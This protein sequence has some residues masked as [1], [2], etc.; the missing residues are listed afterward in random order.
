MISSRTLPV[1]S[2]TLQE[3]HQLLPLREVFGIAESLLGS[4]DARQNG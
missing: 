1:G 4:S 2:A 3:R